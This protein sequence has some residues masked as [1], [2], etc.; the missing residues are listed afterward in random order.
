M[1]KR[2]MNKEFT[3]RFNEH[4]EKRIREMRERTRDNPKLAKPQW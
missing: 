4:K 2:Q 1:N 3:E